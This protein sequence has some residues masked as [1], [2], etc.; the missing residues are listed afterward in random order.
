[1]PPLA[2]DSFIC[3]CVRFVGFFG[4]FISEVDFCECV[5]AVATVLAVFVMREGGGLRFCFSRSTRVDEA[6]LVIDRSVC[7]CGLRKISL[8]V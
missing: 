5:V 2:D 1:M 6:G 7:P 4:C 3:A 8:G